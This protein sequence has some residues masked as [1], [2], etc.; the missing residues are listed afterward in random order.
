[1]KRIKLFIY[2]L[3]DKSILKDENKEL[4]R[5][6]KEYEEE[7]KELI[8]LKNKYLSDL[9]CKNLEVGRLKKQIENK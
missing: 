7:R 9:R 5:K 1:M 6:I 8:D 4:K 3:L 2:D